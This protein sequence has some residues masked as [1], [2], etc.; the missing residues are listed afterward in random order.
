MTESVPMLFPCTVCQLRVSGQPER[1]VPSTVCPDCNNL[2]DLVR[3]KF[4]HQHNLSPGEITWTASFMDDLGCDSLD[5]TELLM[6]LEAVLG[7]TIFEESPEQL[8]TVGDLAR[9]VR[10]AQRAAAA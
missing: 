4:P 10:A 1:A 9:V 3:R 8:T 5:T 6:A 7:V 2:L